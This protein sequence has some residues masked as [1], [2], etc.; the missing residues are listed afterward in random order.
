MFGHG[1]SDHALFLAFDLE[2]ASLW[3]RIW[4]LLVSLLN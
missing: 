1:V 2:Y 3:Q 4:F